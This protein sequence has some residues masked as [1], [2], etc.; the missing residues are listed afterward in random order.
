M[1]AGRVSDGRLVAGAAVLT[2][3][4]AGIGAYLSPRPASGGGDGSSYS[5][6]A[7]GGKAAFE[8]LRLAGYDIERSLEPMT[9]IAGPPA[10]TL[11]V[12]TGALTPS[13][14]DQRATREFVAAGGSVLLVGRSGAEFLG[15]NA[16][17]LRVDPFAAPASH[18]VLAASPLTHGV[19][20]ITMPGVRGGAGFPPVHLLLF[21][22]SPTEPLVT[23]ARIGEGRATWLAA[24]TPLSNEHI[25]S[26][27]NFRLLLNVAGK[28]GDRRILWDE[29]YHGYSRSLWS[30]AAST[31]LPW[32]LAQ[33][34]LLGLAAFATFSRRRLPLRPRAGD[35]RS[36]PMEFIEMLRVLYAR[37]GGASAGVAAA[38]NRFRRRVQA[39]AGLPAAASDEDVAAAAAKRL[40]APAN[41]VAAL[42]AQGRGAGELK[43]GEALRIAARLQELSNALDAPRGTASGGRE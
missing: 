5:A 30:Y 18:R 15:L 22:T 8:T 11:M 9:A 1:S 32:A 23:T 25:R 35:T 43:V 14:Q 2:V 3:I 19:T 34:G 7:R 40:K 10:R 39:M 38:R 4:L 21:A 17:S 41:D 28:P 13:E 29:H 24:I 20:E 42:L 16:Q 6:G 33:C 26:A 36:S 12:I 31:P 37:A 27:D